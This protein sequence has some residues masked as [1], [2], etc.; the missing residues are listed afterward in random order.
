VDIGV[1]QLV[2]VVVREL[3]HILGYK[4]GTKQAAVRGFVQVMAVAQGKVQ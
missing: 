1:L 3:V 2:L 4:S